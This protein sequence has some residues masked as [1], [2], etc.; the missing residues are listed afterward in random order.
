M[1]LT[2]LFKKA[3]TVLCALA[4]VGMLAACSNGSSSSSSDDDKKGPGSGSGSGSGSG[5]EAVGEYKVM[6][7]GILIMD[8]GTEE[9]A[10]LMFAMFTEG[11]DYTISDKTVTLT[12][13]GFN[14]MFTVMKK[15]DG[16]P[17][18]AI[19]VYKK[20]MIM[21]V[22]QAEYDMA[23]SML[24]EGT[25]YTVTHNGKIIELTDAGYTK[26]AALFAGSHGS[27]DNDDDDDTE[28]VTSEYKVMY[29]GIEI[30]WD[31]KESRFNKIKNNLSSG[32]YTIS[33]KTM[34]LNDKGFDELLEF[35]SEDSEYTYV[36]IIVYMK[37]CLTGLPSEY[38]NMF[39]AA[40]EAGTDYTVTHNGKV[41]ELTA[42][43][44]VKFETS[45]GKN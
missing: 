8:R 10:T 28:N 30:F 44:M 34:T 25:D 20:R 31:M 32:N 45:F 41:Y 6:Y 1:K 42:S 3:A 39:K 12:D 38:V 21:P 40:L 33:G 37:K 17:A 13:A 4:L 35:M 14:K 5:T 36:A 23:A 11:T 26:G 7:D 27:G 43:G 15:D 24:T 9:E 16:T 19:V 18:K 22:T 2:N 29:D